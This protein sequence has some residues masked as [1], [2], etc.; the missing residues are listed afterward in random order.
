MLQRLWYGLTYYMTWILY[1]I[2]ARAIF[3][4]YN[5][6]LAVSLD[7]TEI[8]KS[9]LYGLRLDAS[10][11]SYVSFI[12][13]LVLLGTLKTPRN[14][15]KVF[16]QYYTYILLLVLNI[17]LLV[18]SGLYEHWG[19]KVD[20]SAFQYISTPGAMMASLTTSQ[21]ILFITSYVLL[22]VLWM[23]IFNNLI[24]R[25]FQRFRMGAWWYILPLLFFTASLI[26]PL[27]GGLQTM[28]INQSNVY[29]SKKMF[30]NHAAVNFA[31]N[32]SHSLSKTFDTGNPYK[33]MEQKAADRIVENN[34]APFRDTASSYLDSL[35]L[36]NTDKPNIL[37]ITWESLTAKLVGPLGGESGV[38]PELE[39]LIPEGLLFTKFYANGER[40]DKGITSILSGYFPQPETSIIKLPAKSTTL[41]SFPTSL[42]K[43]GYHT[44]FYYGGDLN[45]GNLNTYLLQAGVDTL[46]SGGDF[47]KDQW[48]SKWGVHDHVMM[49]RF[50]K[51]I[52]NEQHHPFFK[53]LFTLSSHE[54]FEFPGRPQFGMKEKIDQFKSSHFY[55]DHAIG[56]FIAEAK[57]QPWWKHTL[58][59]ILADHGHPLPRHEGHLKSEPK[60]HIPML[61]LGGA[62]NRKGE[63]IETYASQA[64]LAYTLLQ[65]LGSPD[66]KDYEWSQQIFDSSPDHFAYYVFNSG[67]GIIKNGEKA[68][69]DYVAKKSIDA[70]S[71]ALEMGA[72]FSQS[73]YEDFL[74][75]GVRK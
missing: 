54:P 29:F 9:F 64:D 73:V 60:F 58:V 50:L 21:L 39:A 15:V 48:N 2:V 3:I 61:W 46:V 68:I 18:D 49:N 23:W 10:F 75:R 28:P 55:T 26:L 34:L 70:D 5:N 41:P 65:L 4:I 74:N 22:C 59:I 36:L 72:A 57:K 32:F 42:K 14:W 12:P 35:Q 63:T 30:A 13:F 53:M 52:D 44:A 67:Y 1:F 43:M 11:A 51:D 45:F 69:Y 27:R 16:T 24:K 19:I 37:I 8:F 17:L 38:V 71:T 20:T 7:S 40:S 56:D 6:H 47:S 66:Y 31:W 33:R 62:L 25:H